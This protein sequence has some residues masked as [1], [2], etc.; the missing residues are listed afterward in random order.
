MDLVVISSAKD[1]PNEIKEVIEMFENGLMHFHIR[2]P[3]YSKS[4]LI[5]YIKCFPVEYRNRIVLHSYHQLA[6][7]YDL[8]GIHL[9][10][11]H[12]RRKKIYQLSVWIKKKLNPDLVLTRSFHK[13][14]DVTNDKREYSYAFLSPVYDSISQS[15]LSAGFSRRALLILI[16]Q[17][18]QP[19]YAMGGVT[20]DKL[21]DIHQNGFQGVALHG[22]LWESSSP[23]QVFNEA[24]NEALRLKGVI[25]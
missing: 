1:E 2:K 13:L 5:D 6:K 12:R 19:I 18:K 10:R 14:T 11:T 17:A 7:V 15:S 3:K 20:A 8:G 4:Q 25:I 23:S 16:P 24:Q 21:E 22:A 9:S